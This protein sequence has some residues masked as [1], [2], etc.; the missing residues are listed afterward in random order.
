[1]HPGPE[2][3]LESV[4]VFQVHLPNEVQDRGVALERLRDRE[5]STADH[6]DL[7]RATKGHGRP[8]RT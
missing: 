5:L 6:D 4:D 3:R 2:G 7:S 8:E 1:M